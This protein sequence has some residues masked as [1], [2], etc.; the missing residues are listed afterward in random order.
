MFENNMWKPRENKVSK[1]EWSAVLNAAKRK[2]ENIIGLATGIDHLD[3]SSFCTV[4]RGW[5]PSW[6]RL[7]REREMRR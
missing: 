5:Q 1:R 4:E 2:N 3:S 7:K 6:S